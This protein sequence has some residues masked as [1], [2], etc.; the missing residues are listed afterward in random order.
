MGGLLDKVEAEAKPTV[1]HADVC[2]DGELLADYLDVREQMGRQR[3]AEHGQTAMM[4]DS[5]ELKAI[6]DRFRALHEQVKAM[7]HRYTFRCVPR[8]DRE[9]LKDKH[10]PTQKQAKKGHEYNPEGYEPALAAAALT[11]IDGE[12]VD[13]ELERKLG[14]F[15][16]LYADLPEGRWGWGTIVKALE[17]SNY[18]G[19]QVPKSVRDIGDQTVSALNSITAAAGESR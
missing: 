11:A 7:T 14:H 9:K 10:P 17:A 5:A 16:K 1:A 13:D 3:V 15:R 18:E 8:Q 4:E 19:T 2:V 6:T 12:T